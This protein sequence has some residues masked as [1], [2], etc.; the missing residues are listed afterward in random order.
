MQEIRELKTRD[1]DILCETIKDMGNFKRGEPV[2]SL[3]IM[4]DLVKKIPVDTYI[5][6]SKELSSWVFTNILDDDLVYQEYF[7]H[8][9]FVIVESDLV[10]ALARGLHYRFHKKVR[11]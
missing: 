4:V 6:Y 9:N 2:W 11:P 8:G 3:S 5:I 10:M 7:C 1:Y